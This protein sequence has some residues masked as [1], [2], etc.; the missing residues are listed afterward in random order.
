MFL[1]R[2]YE[3]GLNNAD[4]DVMPMGLVT[5][6]LTEKINDSYEYEYEAT[7]ADIDRL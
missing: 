3:L 6:L 5:D 7:Q 4:L 1:L 2:A